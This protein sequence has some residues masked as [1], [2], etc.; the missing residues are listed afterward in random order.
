MADSS[1]L[2]EY[3]FMLQAVSASQ[4]IAAFTCLARTDFNFAFALL[5][6]YLWHQFKGKGER[7]DIGKKLLG[8]NAFLLVLDFVWVIV[9]GSVWGS[10]PDMV[11]EGAPGSGIH[12][13]AIFLS[14]VNLLV[15]GGAIALLFLMFKGSLAAR[16]SGYAQETS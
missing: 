9:M 4:V 6:Y 1:D 16:P 14:V 10:T 15:R 11:V 13:L 8:L 5:S 7:E 2:V 3:L 12:N